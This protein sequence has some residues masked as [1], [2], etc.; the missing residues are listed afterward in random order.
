[1]FFLLVE[2]GEGGEGVEEGGITAADPSSVGE[3]VKER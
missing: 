3:S 1:M 2:G